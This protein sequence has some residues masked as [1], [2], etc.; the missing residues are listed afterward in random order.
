MGFVARFSV[1]DDAITVDGV[2][3]DDDDNAVLI[4]E[5]ILVF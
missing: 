2:K 1:D 3:F 5:A 4:D